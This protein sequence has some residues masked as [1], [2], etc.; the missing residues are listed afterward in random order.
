MRWSKFLRGD[1]FGS[2]VASLQMKTSK[3]LITKKQTIDTLAK[4]KFNGGTKNGLRKQNSLSEMKWTEA[5][6][7]SLVTLL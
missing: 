3:A 2:D 1:Q 4:L 5:H 7:F 6:F